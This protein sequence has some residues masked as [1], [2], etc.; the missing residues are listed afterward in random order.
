ME[1][2]SAEEGTSTIEL[3]LRLDENGRTTFDPSMWSP[4]T[5]AK[6]GDERSAETLASSGEPDS[7]RAKLDDSYEQRQ[8]KEVDYSS[9]TIMT[10]LAT[11]DNEEALDA[12]LFDC[13]VRPCVCT[14]EITQTLLQPKGLLHNPTDN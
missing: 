8:S 12:L 9:K 3:N 1:N 6:V 7:K 2:A 5:D 10:N 11:I 14:C 4:H 13:E